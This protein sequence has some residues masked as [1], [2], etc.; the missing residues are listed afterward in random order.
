M[1][2]QNEEPTEQD[3]YIML[4]NYIE[5]KENIKNI[6]IIIYTMKNVFY[7]LP[8]KIINNI[9]KYDDNIINKSLYNK[10]IEDLNKK[11]IIQFI[12]Y[13]VID[14]NK[15]VYSFE[16]KISRMY[17][18]DLLGND[19]FLKY[20]DYEEKLDNYGPYKELM[21][22]SRKYKIAKNFKKNKELDN[23]IIN[24]YINNDDDDIVYDILKD[25]EKWIIEHGYYDKRILKN[26]IFE[27]W[28]NTTDTD[29]SE[30]EQENSDLWSDESD[31]YDYETEEDDEE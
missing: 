10:V 30:T 4:L 25:F 3:I 27:N 9:Y 12:K 2:D 29:D 22:T 16:S 15:Y 21:R 6:F 24:E 1:T 23:V 13:N 8:N 14:D 17:I 11:R 20:T 31:D 7:E 26:E 28:E 19:D 18:M 5:E